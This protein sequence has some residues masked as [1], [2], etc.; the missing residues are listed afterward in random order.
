MGTEGFSGRNRGYTDWE[1]SCLCSCGEEGDWEVD[2]LMQL[3]G[4]G[5]EVSIARKLRLKV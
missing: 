5:S 3:L 2:R 4:S 1:A